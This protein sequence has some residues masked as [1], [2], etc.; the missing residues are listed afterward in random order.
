MKKEQVDNKENLAQLPR[1]TKMLEQRFARVREVRNGEALSLEGEEGAPVA[2]MGH[3]SNVPWLCEGDWVSVSHTDMGAIVTGRLRHENE[4]PRI[5]LM[6]V[7]AECLSL[8]ADR[9]IH[10][11][12]GASRVELHPDGRI[13]V[14]GREITTDAEET[15][16]LLGTQ[17]EIN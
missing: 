13:R 1:P 3:D 10:I 5:P 12:A 2:V 9:A 16:R 4:G 15:L 17:I 8:I 7:E 11:Q 6:R 14:N